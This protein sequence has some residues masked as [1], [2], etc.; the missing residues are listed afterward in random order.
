MKKTRLNA[1]HKEAGA[2]MVEFAGFEMPVEYKGIIEEHL[3]VRTRA[4]LFDVSHM[5]KSSSK[6]RRPWPA[7][8]T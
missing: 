3:A 1:V 6:D 5:G 8:N 4:G 7:C 2:R